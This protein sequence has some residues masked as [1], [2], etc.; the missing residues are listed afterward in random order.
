MGLFIRSAILRST[1]GVTAIGP[2]LVPAVGPFSMSVSD[3]APLP[4][5]VLAPRLETFGIHPIELYVANALP[6]NRFTSYSKIHSY[7]R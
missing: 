2:V 4:G 6:S 7:K 3:L 1:V 5:P